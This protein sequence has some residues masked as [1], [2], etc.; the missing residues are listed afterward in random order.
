MSPLEI[1]GNETNFLEVQFQIVD[2]SNDSF[3][4]V[5]ASLKVSK[6]HFCILMKY[7][8]EHFGYM[9]G[10]YRAAAIL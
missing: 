2:K 5:C 9:E 10:T 8:L 4:L 3:L 6:D 7:V 1:E